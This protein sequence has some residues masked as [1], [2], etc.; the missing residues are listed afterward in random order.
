MNGEVGS[1]AG[2]RW[3]VFLSRHWRIVALFA[4]IAILLLVSTIYVFFW[5]AG[6]AQSSG[7]VPSTLGLWTM[8]H[9]VSFLLHLVFWEV[10]L[11]GIPAIIVAV[12]GWL[13]W[14][15]LPV[16]ERKTYRFFGKRSRAASGGNGVSLLFFIAFAIKVS[17]DGNWNV[18]ISTWS[19]DYVVNSVIAILIWIG[20]IFG[21]PLAIGLVW[22]V[23]RER[24]KVP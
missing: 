10:V 5:F 16:E 20:I 18:A 22:W 17:I 23:N 24:K 4:V 11:I 12:M 19:L 6:D 8:G 7:L 2:P 9:L 1:Q 3:K 21:I 15:R 14:R 13:W